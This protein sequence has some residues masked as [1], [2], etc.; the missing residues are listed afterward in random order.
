MGVIL[1]EFAS[2]F[3]AVFNTAVINPRCVTRRVLRA[4]FT[5]L[6]SRVVRV[7][8]E[9]APDNT[10]SLRGV[11]RMGFIFEGTKRCGLDGVRDAHVFGMLKSDCKFLPGQAYR[12]RAVKEMRHGFRTEGA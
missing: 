3:E 12:P 9:I 1:T 5:A 7:T 2:P 10:R 11:V 6:F 4:V 8:A